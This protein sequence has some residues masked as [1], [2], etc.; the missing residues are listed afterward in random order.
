[1][2]A[3]AQVLVVLGLVVAGLGLWAIWRTRSRTE[4]PDLA[5]SRRVEKALL[6]GRPV[7]PEDR[8][9]ASRQLTQT[10]GY[11]VTFTGQ[12]LGLAFVPLTDDHPSRSGV[13]LLGGFAGGLWL[14]WAG[15]AS[16]LLVVGRRQGLRPGRLW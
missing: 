5:A 9:A 14:L 10:A 12:L 13:I 3:V 6:R 2:T 4:P 15:Y 8:S 7:P 11:S 1:M 16:R